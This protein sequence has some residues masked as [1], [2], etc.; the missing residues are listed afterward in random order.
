MSKPLGVRVSQRLS[1]APMQGLSAAL[2]QTVVSCVLDQR[3][4]EAIVGL[5]WR[6][7]DEQK[8]GVGEPIQ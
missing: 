8:V 5:R 2:E 4:L 1:R 3:V 6:A 7:L